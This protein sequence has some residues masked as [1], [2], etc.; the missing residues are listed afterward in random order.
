MAMRMAISLEWKRKRRSLSEKGG[1]SSFSRKRYWGSWF[2][3]LSQL[4]RLSPG[5]VKRTKMV[6]GRLLGSE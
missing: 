3:L 1:S 2:E 6:W 5:R 4:N